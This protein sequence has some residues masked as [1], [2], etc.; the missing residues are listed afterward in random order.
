MT[1][2]PPITYLFDPLCGWCYG[3]SPVLDRLAALPG[4]AL[5]LA[6]TGLFSGPGA[7]PMDAGMAAHAWSN[8]QRIARLTGQTF[9]EA[10]RRQ[11]LGDAT[12]RFDSGPATL[13]L[14][15]VAET[16]PGQEH[17]ALKAIQQA[18]YVDAA[19]ITDVSVLT[20][21]LAALDLPEAA[22][23]LAAPDAALLDAMRRRTAGSQAL[24]QAMGAQG[25]PALVVGRGAHRRLMPASLLFGGA[26]ALLASLAAT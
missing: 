11:V 5:E 26:D 6:P 22:A 14:V 4:V 8:D 16:A 19:D 2:S 1:A 7:R 15:A 18:R 10:Y 21:L 20:R 3:A 17:A 24:M 9:S 25:V 12:R 23:R 13:A